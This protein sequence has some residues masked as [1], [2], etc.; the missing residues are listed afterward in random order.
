MDLKPYTLSIFSSLSLFLS[1]ISCFCQPFIGVGIGVSGYQ[2]DLPSF[3]SFDGLQLKIHPSASLEAGITLLPGLEGAFSLDYGRVSGEDRIVEDQ[4]VIDRNLSFR[5]DIFEI[6]PTISLFPLELLSQYD[7]LVRPY[8]EVGIG[9]FHFNPEAY[10]D[11]Q[12]H[13]LRILGTEGQFLNQYS[14]RTPYRNWAISYPLGAGVL[15]SWKELF[16]GI[17]VKTRF[18]NTDYIDDVSTTYVKNDL[19]ADTSN[20]DLAA[21]LADRSSEVSTDAVPLKFE[22]DP[23]GNPDYND[24]YWMLQLKLRLPLHNLAIG[25]GSGNL[26]KCPKL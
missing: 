24:T 3:S 20:N 6:S 2:G 1:V 22:G 14:D 23:R 4:R 15:I 16:I 9:Y 25:F 26:V 21:R 10:L 8:L 11:G 12:W 13:S 18:T 19:L 5:S 17:E 7:M